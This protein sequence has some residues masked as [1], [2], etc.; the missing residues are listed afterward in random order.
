MNKI[1]RVVFT[2]PPPTHTH[3]YTFQAVCENAKSRK[4]P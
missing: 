1:Y 2:P 4:V 3:T